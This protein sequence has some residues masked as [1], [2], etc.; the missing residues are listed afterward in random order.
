[1]AVHGCCICKIR[2]GLKKPCYSGFANTLLRF[3][4]KMFKRK[5]CFIVT[6]GF[7]KEEFD[8]VHLYF[9]SPYTVKHRRKFGCKPVLGKILLGVTSCKFS[10]ESFLSK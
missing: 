7:E 3:K 6:A 10:L 8:I 5:V 4:C 2:F 9:V 1:M